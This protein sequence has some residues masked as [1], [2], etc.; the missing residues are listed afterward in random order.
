MMIMI[1]EKVFISV[2][3]AVGALIGILHVTALQYYLYWQ[4]PWFDIPLHFLC[5]IFSGLAV[6]TFYF[7]WF[8]S[9]ET[10]RRLFFIAVMVGVFAIGVLWEFF[11]MYA[12]LT[13]MYEPGF[14][15]D[16]LLDLVFD[17]SGAFV[18][19]ILSSHFY[20]LRFWNA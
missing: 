3:A 15:G 2:L 1:S 13:F 18:S 12:G 8:K 10:D 20:A 5:G 16:T 17:L 4:L 11:E 14:W 7:H 9:V 6:A 19:Y